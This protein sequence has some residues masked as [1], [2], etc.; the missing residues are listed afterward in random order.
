MVIDI[1]HTLLES[2]KKELIKA[3]NAAEERVADMF[4]FGDFVG[5]NDILDYLHS[6]KTT[7]V[8]LG[9]PKV[10]ALCAA[11]QQNIANAIENQ[12][13]DSS[14]GLAESFLTL[15]QHI[16]RLS[17]DSGADKS[18]ADKA[19]LESARLALVQSDAERASDERLN[20]VFPVAPETIEAIA[21]LVKKQLATT[22]RE[23]ADFFAAQKPMSGDVR[24][25][26][27]DSLKLPKAAFQLLGFSAGSVL[28]DE[29]TA[30]LSDSEIADSAGAQFADNLIL[31]EDALWQLTS[32]DR[33]SVVEPRLASIAQK[34]HSKTITVD[35]A[36]VVVSNN[37]FNFF[38]R[39]RE[40]VAENAADIE[41]SD[42]VGKARKIHM[43]RAA[44]VLL[45]QESLATQL[46]RIEQIL[47]F[48]INKPEV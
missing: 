25:S 27:I 42:L 26:L 33:D 39:S 8:M 2:I 43:V 37:A 1:N 16:Q 6:V 32:I 48:I 22:K 12:D 7:L 28:L 17:P 38:K 18:A 19:L 21:F 46:A 24:Q 47:L 23:F 30:L 4:E 10:A 44:A 3:L 14:K 35:A 9:E 31:A 40:K 36:K 45:A 13:I 20:V 34:A 11:I 29:A 15:T 41:V 5:S